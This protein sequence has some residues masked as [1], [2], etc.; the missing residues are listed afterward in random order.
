MHVRHV[1]P[2]RTNARE[3]WRKDCAREERRGE[4]ER[5]VVVVVARVD[6]TEK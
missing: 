1:I 5:V 3:S 4:S 6:G 2:K